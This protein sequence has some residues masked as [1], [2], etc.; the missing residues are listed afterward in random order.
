MR[1]RAVKADSESL[2]LQQEF[3]EKAKRP[4]DT[5][6]SRATEDYAVV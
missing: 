5:K 6:R 1:F 4:L 3:F 2:K